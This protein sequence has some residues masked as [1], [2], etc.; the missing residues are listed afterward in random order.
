MRLFK[1]RK[2]KH[3]EDVKEQDVQ[4][5]QIIEEF[6]GENFNLIVYRYAN[7]IYSIPEVRTAIESFA[8]IFASIPIYHKRIKPNGETE[9]LDDEFDY[10]L[11]VKPNKL[12]NGVQFRKN[13]ITQLMLNSSAFA[14]PIFSS[15]NGKLRAIY[16]LPFKYYDFELQS[17]QAFVRFYDKPKGNILQKYN[18]DNLIYLNRFSTLTGGTETNL[19]LYETVIQAL[20][21]QILAFTSPKK[22]KAILQGSLGQIPNLKPEDKKGTMQDLKLNFDENVDGIAYLDPH[23]K[24][25]PVNWQESDVNRELMSFVINVVYNYFKISESII[26]CKAT[27]I[28]REMFVAQ[29]IKP[30][31]QQME[32]EFTYKLFTDKEI[33]EGHRIEFDTFALSVNVLSSKTA[34][35]SVALR[36]GIL[37]IDE[38]REYI[39]QPNLPNK[40]GQ[41]YRVTGDTMNLENVDEFQSAQKGVSNTN[42]SDGN[43]KSK[44][45]EEDSG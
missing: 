24:I 34:L 31:A 33:K 45:K 29:S 9:Y 16:P 3:E 39:G 6:Y 12:Q 43:T 37:N 44:K 38:A 7:N 1:R 22:I 5:R 21:N 20:S 15:H 32:Q 36:N 23:L 13:L 14:E 27:E 17:N 41:M 25:T 2:I 28:E 42:D 26:N 18:I 40:M 10:I 30:L 19:G 35:F 4:N 11:N 8:D